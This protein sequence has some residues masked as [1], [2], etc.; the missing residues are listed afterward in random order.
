MVHLHKLRNL[1]AWYKRHSTEQ[2]DNNQKSL[3]SLVWEK[4]MGSNFKDKSL[5]CIISGLVFKKTKLSNASC[6][7]K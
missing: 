7:P 6:Y 4:S 5:N 3:S 2:N 1:I